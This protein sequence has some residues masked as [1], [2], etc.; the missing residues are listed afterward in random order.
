MS[1]AS[2]D[3]LDGR[4]GND[5][6]SHSPDYLRVLHKL[7]AVLS[8]T[9]CLDLL[10]MEDAHYRLR[11]APPARRANDDV[12]STRCVQPCQKSNE[13]WHCNKTAG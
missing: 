9:L 3:A 6:S 5:R 1:Q 11:H 10:Q 7:M 12:M 13:K 8:C 4:L 2:G